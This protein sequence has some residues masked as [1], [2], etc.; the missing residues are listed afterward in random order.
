MELVGV[1]LGAGW[2][3]KGKSRK[4][5]DVIKLMNY[6]FDNYKKYKVLDDETIYGE[7]PVQKGKQEQVEVYA[8][9]EIVLPLSAEEKAK[10]EIKKTLPSELM[11]PVL[12]NQ[13]VGKLE[14]VCGNTI[15]EKTDLLA[16]RSIARATLMDKIKKLFHIEE[17]NEG[18]IH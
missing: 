8:K 10:V 5:T 14:V 11:A 4:Y 18:E 16:N 6:G 2:N 17:N 15:L 3:A 1:A 13:V 7:V 12:E 9:E